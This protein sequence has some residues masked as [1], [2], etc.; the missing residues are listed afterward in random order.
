MDAFLKFIGL[1]LL[2][3]FFLFIIAAAI[4]GDKNTTRL[5]NECLKDKKEYECKAMFKSDYVPVFIPIR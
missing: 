1:C 4:E 3:V 2:I 5:I